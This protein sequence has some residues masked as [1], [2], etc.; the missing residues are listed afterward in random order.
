MG[1][2]GSGGGSRTMLVL[3]RLTLVLL[4]VGS[5]AQHAPP[6]SVRG[7]ARGE[8]ARA[9]AS[10]AGAAAL[11]VCGFLRGGGCRAGGGRC[12]D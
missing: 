3:S 1:Y 8:G 2:P 6:V 5:W 4:T 7:I 12:P 10:L 9:R 11:Q